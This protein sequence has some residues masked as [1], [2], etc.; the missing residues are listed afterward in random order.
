PPLASRISARVLRPGARTPRK[1]SGVGSTTALGGSASIGALP[2]AGAGTESVRAGDPNQRSASATAIVRETPGRRENPRAIF[3]D[4]VLAR[5]NGNEQE[6]EGGGVDG[7]EH[8]GSLGTGT[9]R[10]PPFRSSPL[11]PEYTSLVKRSLRHLVVS[12]GCE[13]AVPACPDSSVYDEAAGVG[14]P[15]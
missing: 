1:E 6:E 12:C 8:G 10:A 3:P 4:K 15:G 14:G 2:A 11:P 7:A 5:G 13:V 9:R